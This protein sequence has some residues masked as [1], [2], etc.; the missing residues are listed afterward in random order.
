MGGQGFHGAFEFIV[1]LTFALG[2]MKPF[3]R[4]KFAQLATIIVPPEIDRPPTDRGK[5][6]RVIRRASPAPPPYFHERILEHILRI[7]LA[8]GLIASKEQEA[9]RIGFK[10]C[11]P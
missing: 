4:S 8:P 10:P 7:R 6:Q 11:A 1:Q 9:T 2:S 5:D 3:G